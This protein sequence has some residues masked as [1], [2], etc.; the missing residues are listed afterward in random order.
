MSVKKG[1][2]NSPLARLNDVGVGKPTMP[3]I[4]FFKHLAIYTRETS[5][6]ATSQPVSSRYFGVGMYRLFCGLSRGH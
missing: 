2:V 5:F 6:M 1:D 3:F 4:Y